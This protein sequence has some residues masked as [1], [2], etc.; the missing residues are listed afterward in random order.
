M[1][2]DLNLLVYDPYNNTIY[3]NSLNEA[4]SINNVEVA[5]GDTTISSLHIS[6]FAVRIYGKY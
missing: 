1:L 2:N 4:D 3:P 5:H 6:P